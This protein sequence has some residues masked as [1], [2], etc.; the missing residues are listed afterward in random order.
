MYIYSTHV[1]SELSSLHD[2]SVLYISFPSILV[3]IDL[4]NC[5]RI[6]HAQLPHSFLIA[7]ECLFYCLAGSLLV[8]CYWTFW[9]YNLAIPTILN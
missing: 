9:L 5:S 6:G 1:F 2:G 4:R 7:T 3:F 8:S